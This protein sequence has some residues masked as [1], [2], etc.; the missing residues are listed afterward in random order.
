[1]D[2]AA[3]HATTYHLSVSWIGYVAA[4]VSGVLIGLLI[5]LNA[6]RRRPGLATPTIPDR[7]LLAEVAFNASTTGYAVLDSDGRVL[8]FNPRAAEL[9]VVRAGLI[10]HRITDAV[11]RA[12]VAGEPIDVELGVV[13]PVRD[14]G[15][16]RNPASVQAVVRSTPRGT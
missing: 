12:K 7:A 13:E 6:V 16:R 2:R 3:A 8:T 11:G 15:P 14:L 1:M 10:D 4:V 9:G 5:G